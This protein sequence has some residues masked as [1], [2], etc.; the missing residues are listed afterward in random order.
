MVVLKFGGSS[1]ANSNKIENSLK[2]I[3]NYK[4]NI[5]V[6]FSAFGGV[7]D[8]LMESGKLAGNQDKKYL[9]KFDIIK[10]KHLDICKSLFEISNQSK[11]LSYVQQNLNILE[12]ILEGIYNLKEFSSKSSA[13]I[14]G[15]GEL[16]SYYIIGKLGEARKLDFQTKDS[17]EIIIT[18]LIKINN[19]QVD[20]NLTKKNGRFFPKKTTRE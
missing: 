4:N 13:T 19:S 16:M 18:K 3:N 2:I 11:I 10:K 12:N 5:I 20:L 8:L 17:R 14:S 7:T 6:I 9:K 15:F 1:I